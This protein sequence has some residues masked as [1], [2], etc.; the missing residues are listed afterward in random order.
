MPA[1]MARF[2]CDKYPQTIHFGA[3]TGDKTAVACITATPDIKTVWQLRAMAV[4]PQFRGTGAGRGLMEYVENAMAENGVTKLWCHAREKAIPFYEK[5]GWQID[6]QWYHV[7]S[8]GPHKRMGK[9][10]K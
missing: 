4:D 2:E 10:I 7:R 9:R 5:L 8:I 6:S 1:S 3:F